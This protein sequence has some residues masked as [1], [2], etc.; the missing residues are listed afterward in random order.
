MYACI[1]IRLLTR[2]DV[3]SRMPMLVLW[4]VT[5]CGL[6]LHGYREVSYGLHVNRSL[7]NSNE[8]LIWIVCIWFLEIMRKCCNDLV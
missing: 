6:V 7:G 3:L 1:L 8:C 5:P 2:V 4:V